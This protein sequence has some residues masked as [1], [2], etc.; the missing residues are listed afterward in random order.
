MAQGQGVFISGSEQDSCLAGGHIRKALAEVHIVRCGSFTRLPR[1]E[2]WSLVEHTLVTRIRAGG[3]SETCGEQI[4]HLVVG[5]QAIVHTHVAQQAVHGSAYIRLPFRLRA[6]AL[7]EQT[8]VLITGR[9]PILIDTCT[10]RHFTIAVNAPAGS[11]GIRCCCYIDPVGPRARQLTIDPDAG[12]LLIIVP[13]TR[14]MIPHIVLR[15]TCGIAAR[16]STGI[17]PVD[18]GSCEEHLQLV[19]AFTLAHKCG[20]VI[21]IDLL[22]PCGD[23]KRLAIEVG[24]GGGICARAQVVRISMKSLVLIPSTSDIVRPIEKERH[25]TLVV[26][27]PL[28][29]S[30]RWMARCRGKLSVTIIAAVVGYSSAARTV[31]ELPPGHKVFHSGIRALSGDYRGR[32]QIQE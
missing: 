5:K 14:Y 23:S 31:V 3:F 18:Q 9:A 30:G 25:A 17:G 27:Y 20:P 6:A 8:V 29:I 1:Q 16:W 19:C 12:V 22:D 2:Q 4:K 10:Q 11:I 15:I 7:L 24:P 32:C 13:H 21:G 26:N 28:R